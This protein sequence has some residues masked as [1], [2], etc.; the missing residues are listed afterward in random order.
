MTTTCLLDF[1]VSPRGDEKA[2]LQ[3]LFFL[4]AVSSI[5]QVSQQRNSFTRSFIIHCKGWSSTGL[6][7]VH[8]NW[9]G[10]V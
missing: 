10:P 3:L 2:E 9:K 6:D 5:I 7:D 4:I 8:L 1:S